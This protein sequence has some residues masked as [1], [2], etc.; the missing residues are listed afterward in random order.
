LDIRASEDEI[1]VVI[2][3]MD[4]DGNGEISFEEFSRVMARNYY[5]K[6]SK[7]SIKD[8]FRFNF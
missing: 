1:E 7:E 5:K 3:Q 8:A 4:T 2:N 6:N